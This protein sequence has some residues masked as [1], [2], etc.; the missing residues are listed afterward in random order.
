MRCRVQVSIAQPAPRAVTNLRDRP[1]TKVW[2]DQHEVHHIRVSGV[3]RSSAKHRP[4][5]SRQLHKSVQAPRPLHCLA[6]RRRPAGSDCHPPSPHQHSKPGCCR[7]RKLL[8]TDPASPNFCRPRAHTTG[9][10]THTAT[11]GRLTD[12]EVAES[13]FAR[14]GPTEHLVD[15]QCLLFPV[16]VP[17][18]SLVYSSNTPSPRKH[19][20]IV[21][22]SSHKA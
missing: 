14:P 16:L 2:K 7:C 3:V 18:T 4:E 8:D 13:R 19:Q 10:T 1:L 21:K 6:I 17:D 12:L 9:Q 11:W 20:V 5:A 15:T 22:N